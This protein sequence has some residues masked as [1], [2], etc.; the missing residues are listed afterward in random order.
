MNEREE[1]EYYYDRDFECMNEI[2]KVYD[3]IHE[4]A[5]YDGGEFI[6]TDLYDKN[7]KMFLYSLFNKTNKIDLLV[8]EFIKRLNIIEDI[9]SYESNVIIVDLQSFVRK[10]IRR[11]NK[12]N[13]FNEHVT[14]EYIMNNFNDLISNPDHNL[15]WWTKFIDSIR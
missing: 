6:V 3:Y 1:F 7:I 12:N 2:K 13:V 15:K 14:T 8:D 10:H 5:I 11:F 9:D 4:S